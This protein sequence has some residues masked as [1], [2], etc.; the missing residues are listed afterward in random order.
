MSHDGFPA[1][2]DGARVQRVLAHYETQSEAEAVAEDE[3]A[4]E[5]PVEFQAVS[6]APMSS[7]EAWLRRR[8]ATRGLPV[9]PKFVIDEV[10]DPVEIARHTAQRE[11]ARRNRDWLQAHWPELLPQARG[12][13][14]AV[15]G[16]EA[17]IADGPEEA[18]AMAKAAHPDDDGAIDQY[19]YAE[20][21]PR[22]YAHR[23]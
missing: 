3:A 13:F 23:G 4:I 22:I 6:S 12:R 15:S 16:Q 2:W 11:R 1:G 17:F 20:R 10:N 21:G 18:W 19:V 9:A 7:V 14:L 5:E 8:H